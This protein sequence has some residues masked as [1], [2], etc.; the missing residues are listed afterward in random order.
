MRYTVCYLIILSCFCSCAIHHSQTGPLP[1]ATLHNP[2]LD[3]DFPDPTIIHAKG[4]YYAYATQGS[5][6]GKMN[7]IQ[8]AVSNDLFHWTYAGDALPQKPAWASHTQDFWAPHVLYDSSLQQY[9]LFYSAKSNDTT[10]DKCIGVA[11]SSSPAGPF[12]DKGSPLLTGKGF[13]DIDPMA[14]VDSVSSKKLLYWGSGFQPVRVQEMSSDWKTFLPGSSAL[15]LVYPGKE[16]EYTNLIEGSWIDYQDGNYYLYYSGDNCCGDHANYAVMVARADNP[17]GP[18]KR[19]GE[20]NGSGSSVILAK[21]SIWLAPGHNSIVKDK[22]GNKWIAYHA[23]W[24]NKQKQGNAI[25]KNHYVKRVLCVEPLE[26]V[27]G[28]PVV[29]M[30]Y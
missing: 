2:V 10:T 13:E 28:W 23:I 7:N 22:A 4:L 12:T 11:F 16:K 26:Y 15:A 30:S 25:G 3:T 1:T 29:K 27:D 5:Y 8:V 19:L 21:D 9:V 14:I 18:F 17:F 20:V 6:G 24:R